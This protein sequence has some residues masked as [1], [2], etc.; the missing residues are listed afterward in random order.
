MRK[1]HTT[2]RD[3]LTTYGNLTVG[4]TVMGPGP[5]PSAPREQGTLVEL[6]RLNMARGAGYWAV[7]R[8]ADGGTYNTAV[9]LLAKV[10]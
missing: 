10:A 7:V 9:G 4:D 5:R 8:R 1:A 6:Y 2:T 3:N